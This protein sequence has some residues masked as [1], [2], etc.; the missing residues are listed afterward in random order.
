MNIKEELKIK[1][2]IRYQDDL[3]LFHESKEYL[4]YCLYNIKIFLKKE[5][6]IL[7]KK[8]RIYK[9]TNNYIFLGRNNK[10]KYVKYRIINRKLR[11]KFKDYNDDKI[12]LYS[13]IS[14]INSYKILNK[15]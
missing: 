7:N 9:N 12:K 2:Y 1:Y 3:L 14:S 10:N 13:L 8:T 15:I 6:L 11:R 5:K 4:K